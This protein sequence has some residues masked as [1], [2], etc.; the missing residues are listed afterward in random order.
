MPRY[1]KVLCVAVVVNQGC[2]SGW[3]RKQSKPNHKNLIIFSYY[4]TMHCSVNFTRRIIVYTTQQEPRENNGN[5]R[6]L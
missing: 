6:Y 5:A 1:N 2:G 3:L 4:Y